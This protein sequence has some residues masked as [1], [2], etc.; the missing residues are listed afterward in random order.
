MFFVLGV[1]A[2]L[3]F[4]N[5]YQRLVECLSLVGKLFRHVIEHPTL[6]L[7]GLNKIKNTMI[8][9]VIDPQSIYF[10]WLNDSIKQKTVENTLN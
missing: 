9:C 10:S 1:V 7:K 2:W 5:R 4:D 6:I 3:G 8:D